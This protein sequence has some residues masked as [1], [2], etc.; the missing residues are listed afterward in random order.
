MKFIV[1]KAEFCFFLK[2]AQSLTTRQAGIMITAHTDHIII[3]ATNL[4]TSYRAICLSDVQ[5]T[6]TAVLKSTKL[7][8]IVALFPD[9]FVPIERIKGRRAGVKIGAGRTSHTLLDMDIDD[10]PDHVRPNC[11]NFV[12]I[13]A[14]RLKWMLNLATAI[15]PHA[16]EKRN[17]CLSARL[18]AVNTPYT[19]IRVLATDGNTLSEVK[20]PVGWNGGQPFQPSLIPI[21]GLAVIEKL[22]SMR[23][24]RE[25]L[26]FGFMDNHL[27]VR[28]GSETVTVRLLTG[29]YPEVEPILNMN[30]VY[31]VEINR[32]KFLAILKRMSILADSKIQFTL[33]KNTLTITT[34]NLELGDSAESMELWDP[35]FDFG[36]D[37]PNITPS[38]TTYFNPSLFIRCLTRL[39]D[40]CITFCF[41]N[42]KS[43]FCIVADGFK[44]IIMPMH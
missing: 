20:I 41:T 26:E 29:D 12:H 22:T 8:E 7:L 42:A 15:K 28:F 4:E 13:G 3:T 35:D 23:Q 24:D 1:D 11:V 9:D 30:F 5:T 21:G 36:C 25:H 14:D 19:M 44:Q 18:E 38:I 34:S 39:H 2:Q 10:F 43:S 16:G 37:P 31:E 6:G 40:Q 17:Y 32:L 33:K 27:I